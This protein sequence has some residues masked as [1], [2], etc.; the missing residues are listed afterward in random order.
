[1]KRITNRIEFVP[2][3]MEYSEGYYELIRDGTKEKNVIERIKEISLQE[4]K[5][6]IRKKIKMM[7]KGD[8]I[9]IIA[10][11]R[12]KVIGYALAKRLSNQFLR[13]GANIG[14]V[15]HSKY[16]RKGIGKKILQELINQCKNK[17]EI[18]WA[19][20]SSNNR[21]SQKLLLSTGF[22]IYGVAPKRFKVGRKYLDGIFFYK[23]LKK[24]NLVK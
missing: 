22:K 5:K 15:V 9:E 21:A 18:L 19:G 10:L 23:D 3:S 16:R 14:Y 13:H 6:E 4:C 24:N 7:K 1:M 20:T 8:L 2:L 11:L 17:F 12:G